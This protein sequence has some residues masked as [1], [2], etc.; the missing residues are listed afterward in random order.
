[1]E[2]NLIHTEP[3]LLS[4][5][6]LYV[7]NGCRYSYLWKT[8]GSGHSQYWFKPLPGQGKR[9]NLKVTQAKVYKVVFVEA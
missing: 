1:M 3:T 9:A 7:I 5:S 8:S 4:K 6:K 2:D